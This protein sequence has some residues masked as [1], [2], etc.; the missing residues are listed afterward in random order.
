M[1]YVAC[2]NYWSISI[3]EDVTI[4]LFFNRLAYFSTFSPAVSGK[5]LFLFALQFWLAI[6]TDHTFRILMNHARY[7]LYIYFFKQEYCFNLNG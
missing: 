6:A 2:N 4:L 5:K 1:K 7:F 3:Y